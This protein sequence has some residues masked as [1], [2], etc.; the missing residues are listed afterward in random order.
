M[1]YIIKESRINQIIDNYLDMVIKSL[2]E[3][4][5]VHVGYGRNDFTDKLGNP[6][7][8][9]F[10]NRHKDEMEVLMG[11]DLY[12]EIYNMF[13]MNGFD[14]IQQHLVRWFKDNFDGL[15]HITEIYTFDESDY[16]Y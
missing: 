5:S 15:D 7:I 3:T 4:Y 11:D 12:E 13:S 10:Y 16:V 9:I 1:R 6:K 8:S 14:D 2:D